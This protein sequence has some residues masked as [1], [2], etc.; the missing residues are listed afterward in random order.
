MGG[1]ATA[2]Q[3]EPLPRCHHSLGSERLQGQVQEFDSWFPL[4]TFES[5]SL[6]G[7][8]NIGFFVLAASQHPKLRGL[9][10][11]RPSIVE[12]LLH[13]HNPGPIQYSCEPISCHK[14]EDA[15]LPYRSIQ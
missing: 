8:I 6:H 14:S 13:C 2:E 10:A 12:V 3:R 7:D 1:R 4:V 11:D 15:A 5:V 9:G